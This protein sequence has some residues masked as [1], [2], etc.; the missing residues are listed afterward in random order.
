VRSGGLARTAGWLVV[1]VCVALILGTAGLRLFVPRSGATEDP[2]G[3]AG[4]GGSVLL[5]AFLACAVVGALI[6]SRASGNAIGPLFLATGLL[7]LVGIFSYEYA[8][9]GL[10]AS[11]G[12][13][14][15][16]AAAAVLQNVVSPPTI[17]TLGLALLLF[18]DGRL[19]TR[20]LRWTAAVSLVGMASIMLG[21]AVQ[22]GPV[23]FFPVARNPWGVPGLLVT[24]GVLEVLGWALM[25]LGVLL[26]GIVTVR[27]FR[28]STGLARQQLKWVALAGAVAG[29]LLLLNLVSWFVDLR[30]V[31]D[32]R[33]AL[34]GVAMA[35][36]PVAVGIAILRYQLYDVDVV[37]NRAIVYSVLTAILAATYL[38]LVLL[39]QVA[40]QPVTDSSDLAVAGST[41]LVAALFRPAR[42]S[43][44][45]TVDRRF[46]RSRYDAA[47]TLEAFTADL[48]NQVD[49]DTLAR[50]LVD[51]AST[52][53]HP[54]HASV[55]LR[56]R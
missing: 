41:L 20:R 26:G 27:R 40:L 12:V 46:Y 45:A 5:L 54:V 17:G 6:V 34:I 55:W 31:D 14:P 9:I 19:P 2:A 30:N 7:G 51:V 21:Y 50:Q 36:F 22:P 44:Q 56:E 16:A 10:Y 35:V 4:P 23:E 24:A 42:S 38:S 3:L 32:L 11:P 25:P 52:T 47:L 37:I 28:G 48:R 18:P 13:L 29:V 1:G 39:L 15:G 8:D 53:V 33:S 49:L 43:I